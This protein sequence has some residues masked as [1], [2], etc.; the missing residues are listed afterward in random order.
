MTDRWD[1]ERAVL[2]S[3]LQPMAK[4]VLLVLLVRADARTLDTGKFSPSLSVLADDTGL[5]RSTVRRYLARLECDGWVVRHR[6]PVA[7]ARSKKARTRYVLR[8]PT[9]GTVPPENGGLGAHSPQARGTQ[10]PELGAENTMAR[11]TVPL[12]SDQSDQ[13]QI[14]SQVTTRIV[15]L[16]HELSGQRVSDAYAADV[17]RRIGPGKRDTLAYV[18]RCIRND[19]ARFTP[20][21]QPP[22]FTAAN[23][24]ES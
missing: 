14:S 7:E 13:G 5:D 9:R 6:P 21:P 1:V 24:F 16:I 12:R 8:D 23:G 10:P 3:D 2:A 11:G 20:T 15:D 18:E 19:P 17:A 4:L 22:R